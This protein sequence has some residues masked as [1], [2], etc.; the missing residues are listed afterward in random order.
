MLTAALI[1]TLILVLFTAYGWLTVKGLRK[2]LRIPEAGNIRPALYVL[3]GMCVLIV[4]GQMLSLVMPLGSAAFLIVVA[5]GLW[6]VVRFFQSRQSTL[7][8]PKP[9]PTLGVILLG[10]IFI[11]VLEN[12][13]HAATNPD[14]GIYHAQAIR[15]IETFPAVPGLGNLHTRFAYNSSW[16]VLNA[17]FS[18]SFLGVQSFHLV[19]AALTLTVAFDCTQGAL[20]WLHGKG[21]FANILRAFFLPLIFFVLGSQISSPGTDLPVIL[22]LWL[23][24]TAWL[25]TVQDQAKIDPMTGYIIFI[26]AI[27]LVTIKLSAAP[28]L[29]LAFWLG[30]INLRRPTV[31]LKLAAI[32]VVI[33]LPWIARNVILSGYVIY[34]FPAVDIF[35]VDW[36]IPIEVAKGEVETIQAWGRDPGESVE[37]VM[38]KPFLTW[39]Q[40]WFIEKTTNQK[41]ILLAAAS[42][43]IILGAGLL[44]VQRFKAKAR[45]DTLPMV[46]GYAAVGAGAVYWLMSAPDIRFGYGLLLAMIGLAAVP[47]LWL[48]E[49]LPPS[50]GKIIR[51]GLILGL[52]AYQLFFFVRSFDAKTISSRL[53]LP[54]DYPSLPSEPCALGEGQVWCAGAEAWTHCWYDP[55]PC[56]PQVNEGAEQRGPEWKDGFRPITKMP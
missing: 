11:S 37:A 45:L 26:A 53:V 41:V 38:A 12:S 50:F 16:L 3:A 36:K 18:L 52:I 29:L 49:L 5:G 25:D 10:L 9:L 48:I 34:P 19:P 44:A 33:L 46:T 32:A 2:V 23:L 24:L 17:L 39:L 43:A 1:M 42:S 55:F 27:S 13:T 54:A 28:V 47:W 20:D 14:T 56:I 7:F 21:T 40:L 30:I 4:A 15:W 6:I 51:F 35:N 31:L 8:P 22:T